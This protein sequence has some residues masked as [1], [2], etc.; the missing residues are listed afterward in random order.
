MQTHFG[1]RLVCDRCA[2]KLDQ[3]M[4]KL[5]LKRLVQLVVALSVL[6]LLLALGVLHQ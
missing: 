1:L 6:L 2:M 5:E 3:D 4:A